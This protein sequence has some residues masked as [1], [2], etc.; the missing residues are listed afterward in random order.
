MAERERQNSSEHMVEISRQPAGEE[1]AT[2]EVAE[3]A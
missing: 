1:A 2:D 3:W